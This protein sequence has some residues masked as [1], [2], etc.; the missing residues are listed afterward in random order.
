MPC[1][2]ARIFWKGTNI[3]KRGSEP[4]QTF[5]GH[6]LIYKYLYIR[7]YRRN[8]APL[9]ELPNKRLKLAARVD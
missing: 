9:K 5:F 6:S 1:F 3:L 4:I 2:S 8:S 7:Q